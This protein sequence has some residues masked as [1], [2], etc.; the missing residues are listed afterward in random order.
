MCIRVFIKI[1]TYIYMS[2]C[3]CNVFLTKKI[4]MSIQRETQRKKNIAH[5]HHSQIYRRAFACISVS[6]RE[7]TSELRNTLKNDDFV[8]LL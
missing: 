4:R 2:I 8:S 6:A 3:I 7:N 5:T 1:N